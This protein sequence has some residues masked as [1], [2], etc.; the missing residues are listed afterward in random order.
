MLGS[1]KVNT[2]PCNLTYRHFPQK[3][4]EVLL[5]CSQI[6]MSLFI[7]AKREN[8]TD[9]QEFLKG[10]IKMYMQRSKVLIKKIYPPLRYLKNSKPKLAIMVHFCNTSPGVYRAG[11]SV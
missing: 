11:G 7:I 10:S 4:E 9:A 1:Q 2:G 8:N 5:T 6:F 3:I